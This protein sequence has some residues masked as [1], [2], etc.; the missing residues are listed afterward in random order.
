MTCRCRGD[1]LRSVSALVRSMGRALR[2]LLPGLS[3]GTHR[4]RSKA[5]GLGVAGGVPVAPSSLNLDDEATVAYNAR[6][7]PAVSLPA[8][9]AECLDPE[10]IAPPQSVARVSRA[11]S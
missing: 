10:P 8:L 7:T 1:M 4:R 9:R 11:R 6:R 5:I 3:S 2:R